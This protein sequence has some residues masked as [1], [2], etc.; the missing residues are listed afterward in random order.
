MKLDVLF[1]DNHLLVVNKPPGALAQPDGTGRPDILSAA[2]DFI[3]TTCSKPGRV[4]VGLVHRLDSPVSG[5]MVL[6]RT[7]K[8]ASRLSAC[9]RERAA[10]K[11]YMAI[12]EGRCRGSGSCED[13]ILKERRVVSLV[14]PAHPR[15]MHAHLSWRAV[16]ATGL[17]SL[18][19]IDLATGRPHQIRVQL[20]HRGFP[21]VGDARYGS[22][23][24]FGR[25]AIALH[26]HMIALAHPVTRERLVWTAPPPACWRGYFDRE[27]AA[28]VAA[29][30]SAVP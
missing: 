3:K 4:Y 21:V 15:G 22:G 23:S 7:S 28:L 18:L 13:Y 29:A 10:E 26:C 25:Q 11:R 19:C 27:T 9:F 2:R 30:R 16:A 14:S 12:V 24:T 17:V 6:A 20:A 1:A 5:V 8:A